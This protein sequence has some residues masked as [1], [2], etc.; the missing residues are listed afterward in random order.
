M[1]TLLDLLVDLPLTV[2][3]AAA[4]INKNTT[5]VAEYLSFYNN[6]EEGIIEILSEGFEDRGRYRR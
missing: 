1:K 3:Q 2:K 6:S 5:P 4:Y